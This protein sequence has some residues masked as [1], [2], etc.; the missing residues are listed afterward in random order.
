M[1]DTELI[2]RFCVRIGMIMEDVCGEA[3][4][5]RADSGDELGAVVAKLEQAS[6]RISALVSATQALSVND[7][8]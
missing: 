5:V 7:G 8:D 1:T 6:W 2:A 3:V 4:M